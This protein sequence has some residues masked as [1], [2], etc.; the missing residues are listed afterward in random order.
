MS[1]R[2]NVSGTSTATRPCRA[3]IAEARE[4]GRHDLLDAHRRA[5]DARARP[6]VSRLMS[7]RFADEGGRAGR[8][9]RRSP[10][11]TRRRLGG[12]LHVV[13]EQRR[14]RCLDR[15]E[16][17][18]QVVRHGGEERRCAAR[19]PSTSSA[20]LAASRVSRRLRTAAASWSANACSTCAV[21]GG[22][23]RPPTQRPRRVP[24]VDDLVGVARAA[25]AGRSPAAASTVQSVAG[26]SRARRRHRARTSSRR[27]STRSRSGSASAVE[28]P[29]SR[30]ER[31]GLGSG[32][33]CASAD[34]R[35]DGRDEPGRPRPRRSRTR[36]APSTLSRSA[37]VQRVDRRDE[38][39]VREQRRG[40][41]GDAAPARPAER[42][43]PTTTSRKSS[44]TDGS[45]RGRGLRAS[46]S[47]EERRTRDRQRPASRSRRR[48]EH[49]HAARVAANET[50]RSRSSARCEITW[51]SIG[52]DA[53]ID[54]VDDRA[55]T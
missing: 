17:R 24:E 15:G 48:R 26:A 19:S 8:S 12:P 34:R 23:A 4:R 31:L 51:T 39:P 22:D 25:P 18:A 27:C 10:R 30:G 43:A 46:T 16:R 29:A 21:L 50:A 44:S 38:V 3:S 14:H 20:A 2:G 36:R 9:P 5:V 32:P 11:G 55:T 37:I 54:P 6:V 13:G 33:R 41:G 7:S 40:D 49:R 47:G 1:T 53:R 28:P 35:R 42:R 45:R 52:P